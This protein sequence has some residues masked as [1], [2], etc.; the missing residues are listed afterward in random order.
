MPHKTSQ[1]SRPPYR[2]GSFLLLLCFTCL[3]V[4]HARAANPCA[5]PAFNTAPVIR[6]SAGSSPAS[7]ATADFNRDS[8]ADLAVTIQGGVAILLGAGDG[9]FL[10]PKFAPARDSTFPVISAIEGVVAG[11][12]NADGETDLATVNIFGSSVSVL[13]GKGGG[14]FAAASSLGGLPHFGSHLVVTGDFNADGKQ[15]VAGTDYLSNEVWVMPGDGAPRP[16]SPR[17]RPAGARSKS[18]SPRFSTGQ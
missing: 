14:A 11:D 15:D 5:P 18:A 8:R 13:L 7:I 3:L 10:S 9:T 17:G 12:F 6:F 16:A 1:R 4:T 2:L